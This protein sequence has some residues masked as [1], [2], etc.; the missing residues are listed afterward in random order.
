MLVNSFGIVRMYTRV[1]RKECCVLAR[2]CVGSCHKNIRL[3]KDFTRANHGRWK[4]GKMSLGTEEEG[5]EEI[6]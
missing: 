6:W 5:L 2:A 1:I 4:G 3:M